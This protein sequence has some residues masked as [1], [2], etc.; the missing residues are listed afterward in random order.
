VEDRETAKMKCRCKEESS[1]RRAAQKV[2]WEAKI[3]YKFSKS[4]FK[5]IK[6]E[7]MLAA[8]RFGSTQPLHA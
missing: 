8:G 3:K 2:P 5:D 4:Q 7:R 1:S 6:L